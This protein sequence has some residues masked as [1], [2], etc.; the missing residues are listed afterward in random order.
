LTPNIPEAEALTGITIRGEDDMSRASERLLDFGCKAVLIK[1]GHLAG[2]PVDLL[3]WEG[4]QQVF[5]GIRVHTAHTHGTGCT[6][7]AAITASL[8]LG[9]CLPDAIAEAKQFIQRAIEQAPGFGHGIGP[10]NHMA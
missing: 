3:R 10:L 6:Y 8:A 5:S 7:S 2:E 9:K 1:G 4:N